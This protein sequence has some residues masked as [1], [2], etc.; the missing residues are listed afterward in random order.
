[1]VR[2]VTVAENNVV[3]EYRRKSYFAVELGENISVLE[4]KKGINI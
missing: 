4:T 1:M 2:K 3:R